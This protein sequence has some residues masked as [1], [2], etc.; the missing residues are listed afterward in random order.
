MIAIR[1]P[2]YS[3]LICTIFGAATFVAGPAY[4]HETGASFTATTT[5]YAIDIGYDPASFVAGQS[6]RFDFVLNEEKTDAPVAFDQVWVRIT[7]ADNTLLATGLLH[8]SIGPTTLLYVFSDPG[9]Y[10]LES[11]FRNADGDEIAAATFPIHVQSLRQGYWSYGILL[12]C[13][14]LIAGV[15]LGVV[16]AKLFIKKKERYL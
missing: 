8:Q 15:V 5:Q 16:L 4:A 10:K 2:A 14:V 6:V 11:S 12:N 3:V 9:S 1:V 13:G 7:D